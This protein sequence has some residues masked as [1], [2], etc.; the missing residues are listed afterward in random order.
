MF[1]SC[2]YMSCG[3]NNYHI[4]GLRSHLFTYLRTAIKLKFKLF[5]RQPNSLLCAWQPSLHSYLTASYQSY[6]NVYLEPRFTIFCTFTCSLSLVLML[7]TSS[8]EVCVLIISHFC[9][10]RRN[11]I[12]DCCWRSA[13]GCCIFPT[14]GLALVPHYRYYIWKAAAV[15]GS[16]SRGSGFPLASKNSPGIFGFW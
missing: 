10:L 6:A 7:R 16:S 9:E 3:L 15:Q 11:G 13:S 8:T 2:S 5:G 12:G 14:A 4:A 1:L